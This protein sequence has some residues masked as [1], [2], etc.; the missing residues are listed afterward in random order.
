MMALAAPIWELAHELREMRYLFDLPH[1]LDGSV[2]DALLP[3][4]APTPWP[5]IVARHLVAAGLK[6]QAPTPAALVTP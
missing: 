5:E 2:L 3:G 4:F 6:P 1:R